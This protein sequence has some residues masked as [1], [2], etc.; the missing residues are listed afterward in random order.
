MLTKAFTFLIGIAAAFAFQINQEPSSL[1]EAGIGY[2]LGN[3]TG[4]TLLK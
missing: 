3:V 4:Y 2:R 1:N